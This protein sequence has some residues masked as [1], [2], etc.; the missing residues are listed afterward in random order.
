MPRE[1]K[2]DKD[3]AFRAVIQRKGLR[4]DGSEFCYEVH[5]G[6]YATVGA[7]KGIRTTELAHAQYWNKN[8]AEITGWIERTTQGWEKVEE[9]D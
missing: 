4:A 5:Y 6:P 8:G 2:K 7:A 1:M 3:E 9:N